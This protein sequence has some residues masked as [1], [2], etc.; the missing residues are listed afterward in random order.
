[1]QKL[2][3][4]LLTGI[5]AAAI[6]STAIAQQKE[7][8]ANDAKPGKVVVE[9]VKLTGTVKAVDLQ[10]K[11]VTVDG[12]GGRTVTVNA[13]NARNLDQVKVG[14]RVNLQFTEELALFVRKSDAQPAAARTD[15]VALAP[16]GQKPAGLM[17]RTVELTGTV[18]SIDPQ[19][20]TVAVKG[21][22]GNIRTFHV[23][24]A[25]KGLDQ[26]KPGDQIVL[27][28]TEAVALSVV[29]S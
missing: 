25:V 17:A 5:L 19:K 26:V 3:V 7:S 4:V 2:Q 21:P 9:V 29:K 23:D 28:F 6:H 8:A 14:D 20:R 13:Q 15:M 27:R 24:K 16:K 11:T 18:E 10:N 22:A 1:M 12:S